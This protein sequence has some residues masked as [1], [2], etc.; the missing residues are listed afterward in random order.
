MGLPRQMGKQQV[1]HMNLGAGHRLP[2]INENKYAVR[3]KLST[4]AAID[5]AISKAIE[6]GSK[7]HIMGL[8]SDGGV[9]SHI[10][11]ILYLLEAAVKRG[12]K[13]R[14]FMPS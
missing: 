10:E 5:K 13:K 8:L 4:S 3:R 11:H 2:I 12:V 14:W 6:N 9:H 1:G 7:L